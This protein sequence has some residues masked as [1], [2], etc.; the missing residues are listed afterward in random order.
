MNEECKVEVGGVVEASLI[1]QNSQAIKD[2][3]KSE[4]G[5]GPGSESP[6]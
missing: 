6:V 1:D 5:A 4:S 2:S 3:Q